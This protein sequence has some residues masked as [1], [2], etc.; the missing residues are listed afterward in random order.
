VKK[1][2]ILSFFPAFQPPRSGGELRLSQMAGRLA[3]RFDVQMISTTYPDASVETIQHAP[4]FRETRIPKVG[5]YVTWHRVLK[6]IGGFEECSGLVCSL[7]ARG[8]RELREAAEDLTR[9][10]DIVIHESPFLQP[11]APRPRHSRQLLVY[12]SYNVEARL[13]QDM[14][15]RKLMGRL[16]AGHV[17]RLERKLV[18]RADLIF[19]C[20][21]EDE[22]GFVQAYGADRS[23]I[24]IVPNGVT[25]PE[26]LPKSDP[27]RVAEARARLKLAEN[28]AA[29]FFIGSFHP[30]NSEA[31]HF[32]LTRIAPALEDVM[33]YVAGKVCDGFSHVTI[34]AN[35][36]MLGP[37]SEET[38]ADL[39]EVADVALNPMF[40]GSGTN[41]KMLDYLAAGIPVVTTPHGARG[42]GIEHL[43]HAIVADSSRFLRAMADVLGDAGLRERLRVAGRDLVRAHFSS[44]RIGDQV[45][46]ILD[47]K[48]SR[49]IIM[50]NDYA[51]TPADA[52]GRI[53]IDAEARSLAEAGHQVT[54]LTLNSGAAARRV[55]VAPAIEELNIPR[56]NLHNKIDALL[57]WMLGCSANDTTALLF[58]RRLDKMFMHAVRR[59]ARFAEAVIFCH[60]YLEP[61]RRDFNRGTAIYFDSHNEE[62]RLKQTLYRPGI[63]ARFLVSRVRAAE[64]ALSRVADAVFCVSAEN[65][66]ALTLLA[67]N[68]AKRARVIPNG[69]ACGDRPPLPQNIRARLRVAAGLG[70]EFTATFLGSGHPPNSQAVRRIIDDIAVRNPNATFLIVGSVGLGFGGEAIPANIILMNT[71]SESVKRM[72][73]RTSDLAIN[74]MAVG[75]GTSLKL[76]DYLAAG[77]PVLTTPLGARGLDDDVGGAVIHAELDKFS[78]TFSRLVADPAA[79]EPL[80]ENAWRAA[81]ARYD[82]PVV[83]APMIERI[84]HPEARRSRPE[85]RSAGSAPGAVMPELTGK[86]NA[87]G[88]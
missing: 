11:L 67:P 23:K 55:E 24:H 35:V 14:F 20:S 15:G 31:V 37:I 36:R 19:A 7:A 71:V 4:H 51:V 6:R 58:A 2:A 47:H 54:I 16:A 28:R 82:W 41:L 22:Q 52:G 56:S 12:N 78:D 13:A 69:V 43:R 17:A 77:L 65:L 5:R 26:P 59:E 75:S 79:L 86:K 73:L 38:K 88:P 10:A 45:A 53:R 44:D 63:I 3:K 25:M 46:E 32:L 29:A 66:A 34:P 83:L 33:F 27:A 68:L 8:H 62:W 49:R 87:D 60:C 50:L 48:S 21:Q 1:V 40:S 18:S 74:P 76:F 80:R 30:P 42:L 39:L 84:G 81:C 70:P 85:D 72:L 64:R 9:D 57:G 61:F